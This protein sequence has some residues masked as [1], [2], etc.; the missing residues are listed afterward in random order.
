MVLFACHNLQALMQSLFFILCIG[1]E[2]FPTD[3]LTSVGD[4][5]DIRAR[6]VIHN[7]T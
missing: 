3:I 4:F 6:K 1:L 2:L 5:S 7:T